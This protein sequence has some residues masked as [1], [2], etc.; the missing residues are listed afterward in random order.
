MPQIMIA[1]VYG[2][3]SMG[4]ASGVSNDAVKSGGREWAWGLSSNVCGE[5]LDVAKVVFWRI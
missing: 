4:N 2:S 5:H 3:V 1:A